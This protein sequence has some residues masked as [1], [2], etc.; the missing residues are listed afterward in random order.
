MRHLS[1]LLG[2]ADDA[3]STD[4]PAW[5]ITETPPQDDPESHLEQRFRKVFLE[6]LKAAGAA[7]TEVPKAWGNAL[8]FTLPGAS[9]QW[10]L[11]PQVN[12][13]N[14]RPD[15]VLESND[16]SVPAVAVFT[17]GRSFHAVASRNRLADD[18]EK[19]G[20]LRDTGRIVLA[21]SAQDITDA[22]RGTVAA[23]SWFVPA[24]VA[25]LLKQQQ[26]LTTP[27]AYDGLRAG[28][29]TWLLNWVAE[30]KPADIGIVARAVPMF[31][32][33][34]QKPHKVADG[35][36]LATAGR[37]A[38]L[39]EEIPAGTRSVVIKQ[40]GS[41]AVVVESAASEIGVA[42]VLDDRDE[43][44]DTAHAGAWR[45]WLQL[46]NALS[47][48]DW[49]T[50][51]TTTSLTVQQTKT[52]SPKTEA[53]ADALPAGTDESWL[54]PYESAAPGIER[55]LIRL[56]AEHGGIQAPVVGAEGPQGIPMDLSWPDRQVVVAVY[57]MPDEDRADLT[58]AGWVVVEAELATIIAALAPTE[59]LEH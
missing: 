48:R 20:I 59:L 52:P 30:P 11:T 51:I 37:A 32:L 57:D 55:Q 36:S 16:T 2:L 43:M 29:L 40:F 17:D 53:E 7:I 27:A 49:P 54:A 8:R 10:T 1:A 28:P 45:L 33:T 34:G 39:G 12:L 42:L 4:G 47:L 38:L 15:F 24:A 23:P 41:L 35:V 25:K 58:A 13:E 50:V 46:A 31:M 18:A 26:F 19:R 6:G 3:E 21:I 5:R 22:E 44:L 9:R 14:S 56:L